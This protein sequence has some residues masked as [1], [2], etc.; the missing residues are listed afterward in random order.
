[1]ELNWKFLL[2]HEEHQY[3]NLIRNL[4]QNGNVKGDRTGTGTRSIF[5]A[6]MR[7][8]L[9]HGMSKLHLNRMQ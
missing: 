1:M 7:F 4:I 9:R 8:S 2:K 5:G 6:Q 3:L